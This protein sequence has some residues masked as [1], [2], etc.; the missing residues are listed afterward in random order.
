MDLLHHARRCCGTESLLPS[1]N[2]QVT[3]FTRALPPLKHAIE[4]PIDGAARGSGRTR[5]PARGPT[6]AW[7]PSAS[8]RHRPPLALPSLTRKTWRENVLG[9][10]EPAGCGVFD[11]GGANRSCR[12]ERTAHIKTGEG[13]LVDGLTVHFGSVYVW[14]CT[15]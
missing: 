1:L 11:R 3:L 12:I 5:A 15:S 2:L 10:G 14:V 9:F 4:G 7:Q 6:A 13:G 8:T